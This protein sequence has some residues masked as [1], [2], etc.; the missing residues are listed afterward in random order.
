M[1]RCDARE[2]EV[3]VMSDATESIGSRTDVQ[4]MHLIAPV[5]NRPAETL[6]ETVGD[7]IPGQRPV[8]RDM[9]AVCMFCGH[10]SCRRM[11]GDVAGDTGR[12]RLGCTNDA[13]SI[14]AVEVL[15]VRDNTPWTHDRA[16]CARSTP[17]FPAVVE[18]R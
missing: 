4:I 5:A 3:I 8:A 12:L 7:W 15:V 2:I 17:S 18:N 16:T 13:C 6:L 11:S 10:R 9:P 14:G 1:D